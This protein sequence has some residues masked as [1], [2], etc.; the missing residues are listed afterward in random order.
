MSYHLMMMMI[1]H[2]F[3]PHQAAQMFDPDRILC[4]Q[5]LTKLATP[6]HPHLHIVMGSPGLTR[7]HLT[8]P[9]FPAQPHALS[10]SLYLSLPHSMGAWV[11]ARHPRLCLRA[12]AEQ[13]ARFHSCGSCQLC[14]EDTTV[15]HDEPGLLSCCWLWRQ[16][17]SGTASSGNNASLSANYR[18]PAV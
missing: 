16:Q 17:A 12:A 11:C 1:S 3:Q 4:M 5:A 6:I 10:F 7:P 15:R 18:H 9:S 8:S 13:Y 2:L 14:S